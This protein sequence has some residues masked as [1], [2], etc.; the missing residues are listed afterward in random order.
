MLITTF[1]RG[2][3]EGEK[4]L[5]QLQTGSSLN[6]ETWDGTVFTESLDEVTYGASYR[7]MKGYSNPDFKR[8]IRR[9][10]L[11]PFTPWEQI[12]VS[13][14]AAGECD[15]T[16]TYNA[17]GNWTRY[18][19]TGTHVNNNMYHGYV[20]TVNEMHGIA[21][22]YRTDRYVQKAASRLAN[23]ESF[24]AGTFTA[25]LAK[26][27]AQF[28]QILVRI[29]SLI[30]SF[31]I[32]KLWLE[33]RYAWRT[34]FSEM[35]D[36]AEAIAALEAGIRRAYSKE[37]A[38]E[39]FEEFNTSE[40]DWESWY[41]TG[42]VSTV[43]RIRVSL[44]G[45]IVASIEPP[46]FKLN[47]VSTAWETLTLSF[48]VDWV[49]QVGDW[50]ESM[51]F[52]TMATKYTAAS[53]VLVELERTITLDGA[54]KTSADWVIQGEFSFQRTSEGRLVTRTPTIVP[55]HPHFT[56]GTIGVSQVLDLMALLR[57]AVAKNGHLP[58]FERRD[59]T[60][61]KRRRR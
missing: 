36:L 52:L 48:I 35:D 3:E 18:F 28:R 49:I 47:L 59:L 43:E 21:R 15:F 5:L 32:E 1:N 33:A 42:N 6:Y 27:I 41:F 24:D 13:D 46:R 60:S 29:I 61:R 38:G 16:R 10:K 17:T 53:G 4:R 51:R 37:R 44:R 25:E 54:F 23:D 8:L 26:T 40:V 19:R 57:K 34:L 58:I 7:A 22:R 31:R 39:S 14:M 45:N 55:F 30:G 9:G 20:L 50:I 2:R 12:S 56:S 11:L